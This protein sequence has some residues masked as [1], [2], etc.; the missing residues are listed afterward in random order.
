M[1]AWKPSLEVTLAYLP[2]LPVTNLAAH[3][4]SY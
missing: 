2:P 1:L 4:S 3:A